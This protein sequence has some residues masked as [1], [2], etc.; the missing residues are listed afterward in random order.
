[1][2]HKKII[3]AQGFTLIELL[4]VIAIIGLLATIVLVTISSVRSK[5]R[6]ANRLLTL[7]RFSKAFELCF[8]EQ[9]NFPYDDAFW[10][11]ASCGCSLTSCRCSFS[12]S[13]CYG[14]FEV[15]IKQ[16]ASVAIT[17]PINVS[18]YAYYYFYFLPTATTYQGIPINNICKG[19]FA[20]MVHLEN[21]QYMNSGCFHQP[22]QNEY[23]YILGL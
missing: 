17:D 12:C 6:D 2:K 11:D 9:S 21:S 16:C 13:T 10:D 18:P 20:F 4:V 3:N 22:G 19:K 23:W 5:A 15:A 8:S 1:M 7:D 14:S